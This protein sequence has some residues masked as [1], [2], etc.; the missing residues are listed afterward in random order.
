MKT[1]QLNLG[2]LALS[3]ILFGILT[4][5]SN[6]QNYVWA[7]GGDMITNKIVA[8]ANSNLYVAGTFQGTVDF[9]PGPGTSNLTSAGSNDGFIARYN[10]TGDLDWV[11][12]LSSTQYLSATAICLDK[13]NN[14]WIGGVFSGTVDFDNGPGTTNLTA[15][16]GTNNPFILKLNTSGNFIMANSFFS[17]AAAEISDLTADRY[18]RIIIVGGFSGTMDFDVFS[19]TQNLTPAGLGDI[20][21]ARYDY[22][23]QHIWSKRIGGTNND[24]ARSVAAGKDGQVYLTGYFQGTADMDPNAGVVNLTA[25]GA[26]DCFVE[27]LDSLGNY[28][29]AFKLG[30]TVTNYGGADEG[31][32]IAVDTLGNCYVGGVCCSN[33]TNIDFDPG[34]GT[35]NIFTGFNDMAWSCFV[36]SYNATGNL[37]WVYKTNDGGIFLKGPHIYLDDTINIFVHNHFWNTYD[38]DPG[39]G[40]SNIT[41]PGTGPSLYLA[42][43]NNNFNFKWGIGLLGGNSTSIARDLFVDKSG[44]NCF[45]AGDHNSNNI[46][47]DPGS[48]NSVVFSGNSYKARYG[49]CVPVSINTHPQPVTACPGSNAVFSVGASGSNP[50]FQWQLDNGGGFTNISGATSSSYTATSV[51]APMN[52][53][54][55]RCVVT[56][57]CGSTTSN[58]AILNVAAPTS[59]SSSPLNYTT[60][61]GTNQTFTVGANGTGLSYQ[62]QYDYGIGFV[63]LTNSPVYSGVTAPTLSLTGISI[64]MNN[65]KF[66]C[67]VSGTCSP[68]TATSAF[69]TLTV[70]IPAIINS[71]SSNT[72]VCDNGNTNLTITAYGDSLTYQ[73]QVNTGSGYA[74]IT[75]GPPYLGTNSSVL[76]INPVTSSMN[77]YLYRCIVNGACFSSMT[78]TPI[79]LTVGQN[80]TLINQVTSQNVCNGSPTYF[81][82]DVS[83]T[84]ITYQWMANTGSGPFAV[85]N[86]GVYSGATTDSLSISNST[87]LN[88]AAYWCVATSPC[89]NATSNTGFIN[90]VPIPSFNATPSTGPICSGATAVFNTSPTGA[91]SY[92]W[93][94]NQGSGFVN[95][96]N[97][98]IYSGVNTISLQINPATSAMATYQYRCIAYNACGDSAISN[99]VSINFI[100]SPAVTLQPQSTTICE[101]Y[102][103][104]FLS[105]GTGTNINYQWFWNGFGNFNVLLNGGSVSGAQT[106]TLSIGNPGMSLNGI[107]YFVQIF[108]TCGTV[109]SDTVTL[110]VIPGP[111]ASIGP[112]TM[113]V[114]DGDQLSFYP[115]GI[116]TGSTFTITNGFNTVNNTALNFTYQSIMPPAL[117]QINATAPNGC[118]AQHVVKLIDNAIINLFQGLPVNNS[119]TFTFNAAQIPPMVDSW[120]WDFGDGQTQNGGI[121]PTHTYSSNGTY[122]VCLIGY[123][124]CDTAQHCITISVNGVSTPKYTNT[125]PGVT[126]APNPAGN[127]VMIGNNFNQDITVNIYSVS[128]AIMKSV[129]LEAKEKTNLELYLDSGIYFVE[130]RSSS[131]KPH[132]QKLIIQN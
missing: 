126:L 52:G 79:Q 17:T 128:G 81:E 106:P 28:Q 115:A 85:T 69:A 118:T 14:L 18:G 39:A 44:S 100:P 15:G 11:Y 123:N 8:D 56:N 4:L 122:T 32:S 74:N 25:A 124:E 35:A 112:D 125:I 73:W 119:P 105:N 111:N 1:G 68:F 49:P 29:W 84:N 19:G 9:D 98:G 107:K 80:M 130:T 82:F 6:A 116:T 117:V 12:H 38:M 46:D 43:Y 75:A 58:D 94:E 26:K 2:R 22:A 92:I 34:A 45:I 60:C 96:S 120:M 36:A 16:G 13:V 95:L 61:P 91:V 97:S 21:V 40:V 65:L 42:K 109:H 7:N 54:K 108:G 87:G 20:Y 99:S 62:W 132:L 27:K 10:A 51:S 70:K 31:T 131:G 113:Y 50:S 48:S 121:S 88:G 103:I 55:Y 66:R 47:F 37:N 30:G 23:M 90:H 5:T 64:G 102:P 101:G 77:N 63:N 110:N 93:Q 72:F 71:Q 59:I 127:L 41:S 129:H 83:G 33:G 89:G 3:L 114:C 104:Q 67:V 53:Y 57:S 86:G 76:S 24:A 78:S